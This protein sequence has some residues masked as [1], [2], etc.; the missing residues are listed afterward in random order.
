MRSGKLPLPSLQVRVWGEDMLMWCSGKQ[1]SISPRAGEHTNDELERVTTIMQNPC[2]YKIPDWFLNRQKDVKDGKYSQ[3][4]A[5]GLNKLC[6][7]LGRLKK[8]QAHRGLCHFWGLSVRGQAT[9]AVP[10]VSEKKEIC[11]PC[12]LILYILGKK[13]LK[14][15]IFLMQKPSLHANL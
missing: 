6:E 1:T 14:G 4:L 3:A 10:G 12:L 7:D 8:I 9:E 13:F 2:Q 15:F 11:R 5:N